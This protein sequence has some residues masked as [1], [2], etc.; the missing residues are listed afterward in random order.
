MNIKRL[1]KKVN[2]TLSVDEIRQ[3]Q[4]QEIRNFISRYLWAS[5]WVAGFVAMNF[6]IFDVIAAA[7]ND[8]VLGLKICAGIMNYMSC[9]GFYTGLKLA[10]TDGE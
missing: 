5:V 3:I 8:T 7:H 6:I 1:E 10:L 9:V 4:K 2:Y